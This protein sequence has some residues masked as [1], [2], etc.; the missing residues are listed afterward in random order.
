MSPSALRDNGCQDC[1]ALWEAYAVAITDHIRL[2]RLLVM[3]IRHGCDLASIEADADKADSDRERLREA[4]RTHEHAAHR[5]PLM[6]CSDF[7][8]MKRRATLTTVARLIG[9]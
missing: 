8:Q 6:A 2:E 5:A 1:H 3:A 4:I 7:D 9:D